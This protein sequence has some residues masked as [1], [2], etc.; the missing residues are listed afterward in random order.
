MQNSTKVIFQA[1]SLMSGFMPV[2]RRVLA[3]FAAMLCVLSWT[4]AMA[5]PAAP[6]LT[7]NGQAIPQIKIDLLVNSALEAGQQ[8]VAA[9][10]TQARESLIQHEILLQAA[11]KTPVAQQAAVQ[12]QAQFNAETTLV[13]A[14]LQQWLQQN[15]I[16]PDAV[17]KEYETLKQSAG[18]RELL[19]RHILLATQDEAVKVL[20]QIAAGGKFEDLAASLSQDPNS[21]QAGGL[22]PWVVQ[23][24]LTPEVAKATASLS[25]GQMV[26]APVKG[27]AGF[28]II[29]LEDSR[30]FTAPEFAQVQA[31][32]QRNMEAQAV[33]AH[34]QKLREQASVK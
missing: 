15:P 24:L 4:P 8:D 13:R 33:N 25:K 1:V 27:S 7:V 3:L 9:V 10:R 17:R 28:H 22:M 31:Q 23:G 11:R 16:A 19:L 32:L 26:S 29:R 12:A 30:P 18:V 5:Q 20:G 6:A 14:Y 2:F 21:K 34:I